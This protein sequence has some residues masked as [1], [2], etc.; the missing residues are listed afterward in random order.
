MRLLFPLLLALFATACAGPKKPG[1]TTAKGSPDASASPDPA[2]QAPYPASELA[3]APAGPAWS[4]SGPAGPSRGLTADLPDDG[5]LLFDGDTSRGALGYAAVT[6]GSGS[7]ARKW[8]ALRGRMSQPRST[9]VSYTAPPAPAGVAGTLPRSGAVVPPVGPGRVFQASAYEQF[10]Q[11]L[12]TTVYPVLTRLGWH[13]R[14]RRGGDVPMN[15]YRITVHHTE[16]HQTFSAAATAAEV[17][18]IQAFHMGPERGWDDIAYHF[19][20]DGQGRI[21]EGRP[22]NVLGAHAK[23]ANDGNI[24]IALLGNFD[25]QQPTSSQVDSLERLSSYLAMKYGIPIQQDGRFEPHRHWDN[26][27]CP[28]RNVVARLPAFRN[29]IE[30]QVAQL[31]RSRT[32]AT[33]AALASFTPL[34]V[35]HPST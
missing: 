19:L 25:V 31:E 24:G 34:V 35:T 23:Y 28:G 7:N 9:G 5:R 10:Q 27:S 18:G 22:S 33:T 26:T 16:G 13:A 4:A 14:S 30:Q 3:D 1:E 11:S 12:Y 15:P 8:A 21:A 20:I 32:G 6:A 29:Q 2:A 17:R